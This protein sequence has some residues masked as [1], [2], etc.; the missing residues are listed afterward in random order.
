M[1]IIREF[2]WPIPG[3]LAMDSAGDLWAI[4]EGGK[5][6][7]SYS[8][9]GKLRLEALPLPTG[10]VPNGLGFDGQGRLLVCD[11]GPRQQVHAFDIKEN[12]A[13]AH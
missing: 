6:V 13:E 2:P 4:C 8:A 1:E 10:S 7:A 11:N 12:A 9:D 5:R 3:R